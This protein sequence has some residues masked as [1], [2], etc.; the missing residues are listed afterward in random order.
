MEAKTKKAG[1]AVEPLKL[2]WQA[3]MQEESEAKT[4]HQVLLAAQPGPKPEEKR[5][6]PLAKEAA[7]LGLSFEPTEKDMERLSEF[8]K[9]QEVDESLDDV[10]KVESQTLPSAKQAKN[11]DDEDEAAAAAATA[12]A[13][14]AE[15]A[16]VQGFLGD[17]AMGV[18]AKRKAQDKDG[19]AVASTEQPAASKRGRTEEP[20]T[21][22]DAVQKEMQTVKDKG[23][24]LEKTAGSS[25]QAASGL[26]LG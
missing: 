14:A 21:A 22:G 5:S 26:Q 6:P 3:A 11:P 15:A 7:K 4:A 24:L 1:E 9:Q 18:E 25:S 12:A 19:A 20:D 23:N 8:F 13:D 16:A 10:L 2:E 17:E